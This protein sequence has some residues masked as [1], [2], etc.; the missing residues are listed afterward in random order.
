MSKNTSIKKKLAM[1]SCNNIR[2]GPS[3]AFIR[4]ENADITLLFTNVVGSVDFILKPV[5]S[6]DLSLQ[7]NW[8]L[9]ISNKGN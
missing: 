7:S 3:N 4:F 9:N 1:R 6:T 5:L 8:R 2:V